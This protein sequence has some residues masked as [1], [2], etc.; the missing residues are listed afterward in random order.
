M[1]RLSV[2]AID[3]P[4]P[5]TVTPIRASQPSTPPEDPIPEPVA[6]VQP[7][8]WIPSPSQPPAAPARPDALLAAFEALGYALSARAILLIGVL[9]T[10][11]LGVFVMLT[12]DVLRVVALGIYATLV[13]LPLVYLERMKGR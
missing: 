11:A 4:R 6:A 10:C 5:A 9:S 12:P 3:D 7:A 8:Q 1:A 13:V 2:E